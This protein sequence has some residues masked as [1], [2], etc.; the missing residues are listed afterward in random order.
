MKA[1]M[2]AEQGELVIKAL[3]TAMQDSDNVPAATPVAQRYA[4]EQIDREHAVS[5]VFT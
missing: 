3:Q 4:G 1:R 2:P 5:F